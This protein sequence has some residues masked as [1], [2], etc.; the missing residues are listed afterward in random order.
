MGLVEEGVPDGALRVIGLEVRAVR[1]GRVEELEL[2]PLRITFPGEAFTNYG[3]G[4][5][6]T[7]HTSH[8]DATVNL[9]LPTH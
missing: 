7:A 3:D 2:I 8:G 6:I 9:A 4:L 1:N 5:S